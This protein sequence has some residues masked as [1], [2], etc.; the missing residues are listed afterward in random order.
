M[1]QF[2]AGDLYEVFSNVENRFFAADE[3]SGNCMANSAGLKVQQGKE[4]TFN[5]SI[6]FD[7]EIRIKTSKI[8]EFSVGLVLEVQGVPTSSALNFRL[9]GHTESI[10]FRA[11]SDYKILQ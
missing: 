6:N 2:Y 5:V 3:A 9:K 10:T 8:S 11:Y 4:D 7:C 1:F